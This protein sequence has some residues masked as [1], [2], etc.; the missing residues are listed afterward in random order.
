MNRTPCF[1]PRAPSRAPTQPG[2]R[3]AL[4]MALG[5]LALLGARRQLS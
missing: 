1:D 2:R 3:P 5:L 4:L